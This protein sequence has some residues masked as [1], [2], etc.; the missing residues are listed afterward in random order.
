[1]SVFQRT[2]ERTTNRSSIR[3]RIGCEPLENRNLMTS[4]GF[5]DGCFWD[6][7]GVGE[8]FESGLQ[9]EDVTF[10]IQRVPSTPTRR[11][12][13]AVRRIECPS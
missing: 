4:V 3:R 10:N 9:V 1:M 11:W 2:N 6:S 7:D 13:S 8:V 12:Q 5:A